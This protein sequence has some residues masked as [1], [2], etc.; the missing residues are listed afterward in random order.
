MLI[1]T[2]VDA[3]SSAGSVR[4]GGNVDRKNSYD[5]SQPFLAICHDRIEEGSGYHDPTNSVYLVNPTEFALDDVQTSTSGLLVSEDEVVTAE[6]GPAKRW[7]LPARSFVCIETTSDR[8]FDELACWWNVTFVMAGEKKT[9]RFEAA[10]GLSDAKL[11]TRVPV[12]H[13]PGRIVRLRS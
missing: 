5:T 3:G 8:E 4:L 12:V 13:K 9:L 2:E 6:G 11:N 10:K 1:A 7:E